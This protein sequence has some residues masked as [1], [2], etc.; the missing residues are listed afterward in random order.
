M[1]GDDFGD[2]CNLPNKRI[3]GDNH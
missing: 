3:E 1:R 2:V